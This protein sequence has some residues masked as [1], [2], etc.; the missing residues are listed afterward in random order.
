MT[1]ESMSPWLPYFWAGL[2]AFSILVYI[3]VDGYDFGVGMLFATAK[4]DNER[5]AIIGAIAPFWD[6]N[7]TWLVIVGACLFGAFPVIYAIFL[8]AFYLPVVLLLIGLIFR[9][10]A[11]EYRH[12]ALKARGI[13]EWGFVIGSAVAAI[14][15]GAAIGTMILGLPVNG[16]TYVGNGWE[17]L[18]PF[19]V[20]CGVGLVIG[21]A[22]LGA[23]WLILKTEGGVAKRARRQL[24]GLSVAFSVFIFIAFLITQQIDLQ[25]RRSWETA[26]LWHWLVP[27]LGFIDLLG[28][29]KSS[30]HD[31]PHEQAPFAWAMLIFVSAFGALALSFWPYMMPYSLTIEQ[32][33]APAVSLQ[34]MFWGAIIMF[35]LVIFYFLRVYHFFTGKSDP[36]GYELDH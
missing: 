35:P 27:A 17:W 32:A 36:V 34:F 4:D 10:V 19:P 15:Q 1:L 24:R 28:V 3:I 31:C 21:Y 9:G 16:T 20:L 33:A 25:V 11:F 18:A 26:P 29:F 22:M 23:G 2:I 5:N 14:V 6:G 12:H 8:S 13:W 7:E 30:R